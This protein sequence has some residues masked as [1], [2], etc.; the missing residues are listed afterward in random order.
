VGVSEIRARPQFTAD[1]DGTIV[2]KTNG[3]RSL[4][5]IRFSDK[6]I[7]YICFWN[8]SGVPRPSP[9]PLWPGSEPAASKEE[10]KES[11]DEVVEEVKEK[12]PPVVKME[13]DCR[14]AGFS[15]SHL[16]AVKFGRICWMSIVDIGTD[17]SL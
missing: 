3:Y 6:D 15:S 11:K 8:L 1:L 2:I 7:C 12:A 5:S 13:K 14:T 9:F 16:W 17:V 4:G 10:S